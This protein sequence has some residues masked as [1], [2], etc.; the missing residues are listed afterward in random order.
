MC[1][2][3]NSPFD[4]K[5]LDSQRELLKTCVSHLSSQLYKI[6]AALLALC[7]DVETASL[8]VDGD[9]EARKVEV[10]DLQERLFDITGE[11]NQTLVATQ[12]VI[13]TIQNQLIMEYPAHLKCR[14]QS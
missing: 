12:L 6:I 3:P 13:G 4:P 5:H 10:V 9:P 2:N 1:G 7:R 11:A 14:E 8:P